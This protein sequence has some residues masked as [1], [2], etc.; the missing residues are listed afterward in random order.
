MSLKTFF[1]KVGKDILAAVEYPFKHAAQLAAVL[2]KIVMD[3]GEAVAEAPEAKQLLIGL[4]EAFEKLGPD[5]LADLAAKGLNFAAD[6]QTVSDLQAA[7]RYL[8]GTFF[9]GVEKL[10]D[11]LVDPPVV[12]TSGTPLL[13]VTAP[14]AAG[15]V[16]VQHS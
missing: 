7:F 10:Y 1:V 14:A 15:G 2:G 4:V 11:A 8:T 9:P 6:A 5:V 16:I 3:S 12:V 13:P